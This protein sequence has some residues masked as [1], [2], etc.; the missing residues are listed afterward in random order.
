MTSA[1]AQIIAKQIGVKVAKPTTLHQVSDSNPDEAKWLGVP[2]TFLGENGCQVYDAR[3]LMCRTLV[4]MDSD[5]RLCRIDKNATI[6]VPYAN[7]T[8]IKGAMVFIAQKD[9]GI[10]DVREWFPEGLRR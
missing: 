3:P 2:C 4:N 8:S 9:A 6:N 1:E 7:A 10:A 5:E